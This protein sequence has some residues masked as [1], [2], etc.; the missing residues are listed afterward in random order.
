MVPRTGIDDLLRLQREV[1]ERIALEPEQSA[2][3]EALCLLVEERLADSVC[4]IMLLDQARGQ[5][6]V[7]AAPCAPPQLVEELNGLVPG[8]LAGSCGTAVFTGQMV[9]VEDTLTD[10]RWRSMRD[11]ALHFGIRSC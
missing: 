8:E 6:T 3:H 2:T 11:T 10:P 5:L 9:I 4:S 1:I 7:V